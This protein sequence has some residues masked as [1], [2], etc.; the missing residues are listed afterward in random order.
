[1]FRVPDRAPPLVLIFVKPGSGARRATGNTLNVPDRAAR[2]L[3][4]NVTEKK[5]YRYWQHFETRHSGGPK[6]IPKPKKSR[7]SRLDQTLLARIGVAYSVKNM[8]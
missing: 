5:P 1:M 4:K 8:I 6:E 7:L 2:C 3:M